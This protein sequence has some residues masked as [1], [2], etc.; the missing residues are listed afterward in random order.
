MNRRAPRTQKIV[1]ALVWA[2]DIL[3]F[4]VLAGL[5]ALAGL[6]VWKM[7]LGEFAPY[8]REMSYAALIA[9]MLIYLLGHLFRILRLAML[10]GG[11]RIGFRTAAS[12]HLFSAAASLI[13]PLKSGELYRMTEMSNII[14][15]FA[16]SFIIVLW[17]RIF[18]VLALV[19]L[20]LLLGSLSTANHSSDLAVLTLV[21]LGFLAMCAIVFFVIP[22]SLRRLTLLI[23]LR[24]D[25]PKSVWWLHQLTN[26]RRLIVHAPLV[27]RGKVAS[28]IT[29]T[30]MIWICEVASVVLSLP[31]SSLS[32][33][34]ALDT[35]VSYFAALSTG[36][37]LFSILS[38]SGNAIMATK[39]YPHIIATQIP[40]AL[41]GLIAGLYYAKR[42]NKRL[43][44]SGRVDGR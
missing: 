34:R 11:W 30:A 19:C 7:A 41:I 16:N 43:I 36:E 4:V 1:K 15:S 40:L 26:L 3:F 21:S 27:V 39:F 14:G 20:A 32:I 23:I 6:I 29:L 22:D 35:L 17:E 9:A 25:S 38:D 42:R 37:T 12:F 18:D 33:E 2:R 24:Y 44:A 5:M 10:I 8:L 28:L 31:Q 13:A